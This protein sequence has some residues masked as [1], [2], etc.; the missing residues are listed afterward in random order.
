MLTERIYPEVIVPFGVASRN[1]ARESLVE[2]V[3]RKQPKRDRETL[4]PVTALVDHA[5]ARRHLVEPEFA[6]RGMAL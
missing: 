6:Q 2:A 5:R 1:V 3:A 4:L